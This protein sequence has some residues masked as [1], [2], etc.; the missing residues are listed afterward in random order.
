[1]TIST[2]EELHSDKIQG[3]FAN[4]SNAEE[5]H[6][7]CPVAGR[8]T[9]IQ[10]SLEAAITVADADIT[11]H[12]AADATLATLTVVVA[13]S[14]VGSVHALELTTDVQVVDGQLLSIKTDG[15]S[16]GAG[17]APFAVWVERAGR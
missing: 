10:V 17:V 16:T 12:D 8:V 7:L 15:A 3:A 13:D 4:I 6:F 2:A 11:L 1:M 5:I 14:G 9:K